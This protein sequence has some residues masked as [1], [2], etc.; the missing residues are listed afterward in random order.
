MRYE[1]VPSLVKPRAKSTIKIVIIINEI[2]PKNVESEYTNL[3]N[4]GF[5]LFKL[6]LKKIKPP[7][8]KA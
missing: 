1:A 4:L 7:I 2:R 5:L 6:I 8:N 3:I